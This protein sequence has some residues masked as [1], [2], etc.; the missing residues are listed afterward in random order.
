MLSYCLP[1]HQTRHRPP[2]QEVITTS[3]S[4]YTGPLTLLLHCQLVKHMNSTAFELHKHL[5]VYLAHTEATA[6]RLAVTPNWWPSIKPY[7]HKEREK[8]P[9]LARRAQS[10]ALPI[11]HS[12]YV[13]EVERGKPPTKE[14]AL[15]RLEQLECMAYIDAR[16]N[17]ARFALAE[18][19]GITASGWGACAE[20]DAH[21]RSR[22]WVAQHSTGCFGKRRVLVRILIQQRARDL[23][24]ETAEKSD[25]NKWAEELRIGVLTGEIR[26]VDWPS[27]GLFEMYKRRR[28]GGKR[29]QK[30]R[31]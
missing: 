8:Y 29:L 24:L 12:E 15:D 25:A 27:Q 2:K 21:R 5:T 11:L 13:A 10:T 9:M 31:A 6:S 26:K 16:L 7:W 14:A 19:E 4:E 20:E 1:T 28:Y 17:R 18:I 23:G 30:R 22:L 3:S